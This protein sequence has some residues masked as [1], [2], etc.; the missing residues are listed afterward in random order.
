M[1]DERDKARAR[2]GLPPLSPAT[3]ATPAAVVDEPT[4]YNYYTGQYVSSPD[5]IKPNMD[6]GDEDRFVAEDFGTADDDEEDDDDNPPSGRVVVS[7]YVDEA[8]GDTYAIY[9]DGSRELLSA[10]T[11]RADEGCSCKPVEN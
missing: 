2:L 11:R 4:Y 1:V 9:S 3:T 5:L 6:I 10:G 8:T 7:T